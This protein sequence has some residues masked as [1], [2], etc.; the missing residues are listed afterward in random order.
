MSVGWPCSRPN[1]Q[2]KQGCILMT[3]NATNLDTLLDS[4]VSFARHLKCS[5]YAITNTLNDKED[6]EK[7]R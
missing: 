4:Y 2:G 1:F 6:R 7:D 5:E 3:L